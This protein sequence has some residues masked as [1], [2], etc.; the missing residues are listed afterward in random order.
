MIALLKVIENANDKQAAYE[1]LLF[2]S[3][4]E[5]KKH[6]FISRRLDSIEEFLH[7]TYGFNPMGLKGQPVSTILETAIILFEL[8]QDAP[9]PP[10]FFY[11]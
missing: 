11:G 10:Y 7:S 4:G 3:H 9:C 5:S 1:L 8:A 2:L 6:E